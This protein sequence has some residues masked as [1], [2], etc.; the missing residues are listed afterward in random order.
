M[1]IV[2]NICPVCKESNELEA[3]VCGNCG[4]TL[5]ASSTDSGVMTKETNAQVSDGAKDW[6]IDE[7]AIPEN[8]IAVF[9]QGEFSPIHTDSR[10]E[11]V[12][13]RKASHRGP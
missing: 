5:E 7:A 9:L 2:E 10:G 12:I 8:G 13:G 3:V 6:A 11:F 4:A 1:N